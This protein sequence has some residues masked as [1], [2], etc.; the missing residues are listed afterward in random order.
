MT[1][2]HRLRQ[3]PNGNLDAINLFVELWIEVLASL[4]AEEDI[5][6][7]QIGRTLRMDAFARCERSI[8]ECIATHRMS[9]AMPDRIGYRPIMEYIHTHVTTIKPCLPA[10][11]NC[12]AFRYQWIMTALQPLVYNEMRSNVMLAVGKRLP[13]ELMD[14]VF[15]QVLVMEGIAKCPVRAG[16]LC[17]LKRHCLSGDK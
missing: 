12:R 7:D 8:R 3:L 1:E 5:F 11:P 14:C 2:V 16:T 9:K 6:P 17:K 10:I 15:E 13:A 4:R